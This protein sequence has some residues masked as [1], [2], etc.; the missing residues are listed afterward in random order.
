MKTNN[1][2]GMDMNKRN[3]WEKK[4]KVCEDWAKNVCNNGDNCTYEHPILCKRWV[5]KGDCW[6][7]ENKK[8]KFYHP[9]LCWQYLGQRYCTNGKGCRYRHIL[10]AKE[11]VNNFERINN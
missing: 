2:K 10:E 9:A 3:V 8:C 6:G 7:W 4:N 1:D 11:N 5:S